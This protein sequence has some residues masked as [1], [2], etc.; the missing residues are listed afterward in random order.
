[1]AADGDVSIHLRRQLHS[2]MC[3]SEWV[4]EGVQRLGCTWRV[5][6][7]LLKG[8]GESKGDGGLRSSVRR[9]GCSAD[10][11]YMAWS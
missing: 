6:V 4:C 3:C 8:F 7:L 2:K 10:D 1:M 5:T 11:W 9:L